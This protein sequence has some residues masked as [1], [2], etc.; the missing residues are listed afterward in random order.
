MDDIAKLSDEARAFVEEAFRQYRKGHFDQVRFKLI[1]A[2]E[3]APGATAITEAIA[4]LDAN[5]IALKAKSAGMHVSIP[6]PIP[7][8]FAN[9]DK[10]PE[11][12]DGV[13]ETEPKQT[14]GDSGET[15]S[16]IELEAE[17]PGQDEQSID[18]E[19][20]TADSDRPQTMELDALPPGDSGMVLTGHL[21]E[22]TKLEQE[23][24][25]DGDEPLDLDGDDD[26]DDE[27]LGNAFDDENL[28]EVT[29][30]RA[31]VESKTDDQSHIQM[32][33]TRP[34]RKDIEPTAESENARS[35]RTDASGFDDD[36]PTVARLPNESP[37]PATA[38]GKAVS[39]A[40]SK[41]SA[42]SP[43]NLLTSGYV[44]M[45]RV[46]TAMTLEGMPVPEIVHPSQG[47]ETNGHPVHQNSN[48]TIQSPRVPGSPVSDDEEPT[49]DLSR[50]SVG[51]MV[52]FDDAP[53]I[54]KVEF[55]AAT[56]NKLLVD[57]NDQFAPSQAAS[58]NDFDDAPT[59]DKASFDAATTTGLH[60]KKDS[61]SKT[62]Q[63][64]PERDIQGNLDFD[65]VPTI[66]KV[67]FDAATT[68]RL[69][70]KK[71]RISKTSQDTPERDIEGNLD[72]DDAPTID[73]ASF[74]AK[75]ASKSAA[76]EQTEG[77][78]NE[79]THATGENVSAPPRTDF[80]DNAPTIGR[81]DHLQVSGD[82]IEH[83][84]TSL[85]IPVDDSQDSLD[86]LNED[87]GSDF[88]EQPTLEREAW[89]NLKDQNAEV[90]DVPQ[91]LQQAAE[92]YAS[93]KFE[94][95]LSLCRQMEEL[96]GANPDLEALIKQNQSAL[97]DRF[98]TRIGGV[99]AI[100]IVVATPEALTTSG[101]DHRA[102]F[103]LT[104]IDGNLT[105]D[106]I[107]VISGM[108]RLETVRT[109]WNMLSEGLVEIQ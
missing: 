55:D 109:L 54:G 15:E 70:K 30:S 104:R 83:V 19:A 20:L 35:S 2:A 69:H 46:G 48:G 50:L 102:A 103:L 6:D 105:V 97:T 99:D 34:S 64:A 42:L 76:P 84:V 21:F 71:D 85:E 90:P 24:T 92:L 66:D 101:I 10:E 18:I 13:E 23:Q 22:S 72:F 59:I 49:G 107:L 9:M 108:S 68:T 17:L 57:R 41:P 93:G 75:S 61:I 87:F 86:S 100:P 73:K 79:P 65:D 98:L 96:L 67:S 7:N 91:Q 45:E 94:E 95:S 51:H 56:T 58:N 43:S 106:E 16:A 31:P 39:E 81:V 77:G 80:D 89:R 29:T 5:I 60:K 47:A 25:S 11:S 12:L 27:D 33:A 74:D 52:Q 44:D 53:T 62:S 4:F 26:L 14:P 32:T 38:F 37:A 8:L 3:A 28:D 63:D 88:D 78:D 82:S 1:R 40:H 36:A